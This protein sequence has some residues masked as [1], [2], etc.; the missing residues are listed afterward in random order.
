MKEVSVPVCPLLAAG[1]GGGLSSNDTYNCKVA[2]APGPQQGG[3]GNAGA[4]SS[5]SNSGQNGGFGLGG[6]SGGGADGP[7]LG[8]AAVAISNFLPAAP[9]LGIDLLSAV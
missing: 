3:S 9:L 8:T 1:G 7:V 5:S 2:S 4:G 6:D